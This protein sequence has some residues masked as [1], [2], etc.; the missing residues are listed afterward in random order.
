MREDTPHALD[1]TCLKALMESNQ[2]AEGMQSI[3][4]PVTIAN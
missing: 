4:T 1:V 3:Q 2:G